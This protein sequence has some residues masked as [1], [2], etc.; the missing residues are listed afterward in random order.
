MALTAPHSEPDAKGNFGEAGN[1]PHWGVLFYPAKQAR[2]GPDG[3][4]GYVLYVPKGQ[5]GPA[6]FLAD[7]AQEGVCEP[8]PVCREELAHAV[9]ERARADAHE[10][11]VWWPLQGEA[12]RCQH[13]KFAARLAER[14]M[15]WVKGK[16]AEQERDW[17]DKKKKI[18]EFAKSPDPYGGLDGYITARVSRAQC[19]A[20]TAL[21][22]KAVEN[23]A[24]NLA[25]LRV[26]EDGLVAYLT[27]AG[28]AD[29]IPSANGAGCQGGNDDAKRQDDDAVDDG[30]WPAAAPTRSASVCDE[31]PGDNGRD[32]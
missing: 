30:D 17:E 12:R 6:D 5:A 20:Q 3:V 28:A 26:L 29:R 1:K 9:E 24:G 23:G 16:Q 10:T 4:F 11:G 14:R 25:K 22:R 18:D 8:S 15:D 2:P 32:Q 31:C 13:W 19:W 7:T 27:R 21:G